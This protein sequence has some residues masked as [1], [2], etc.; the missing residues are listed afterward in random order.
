VKGSH[1]RITDDPDHGPLVIA[2]E[3]DL[4]PEGEVRRAAFKQLVLD[5]SLGADPGGLHLPVPPRRVLLPGVPASASHRRRGA[6]FAHDHREHG[7]ASVGIIAD[8][9]EGSLARL[10][11]RAVARLLICTTDRSS[12]T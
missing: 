2:S 7:P 11:Y 9:Q 5:T 10:Q 12:G 1:E 4:L 3:P 8:H 6:L